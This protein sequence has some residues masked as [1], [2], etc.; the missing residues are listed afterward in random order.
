MEELILLKKELNAI[1]VNFNQ[2]VRQ[3]NSMKPYDLSS[4][5]LKTAQLTQSAL[6]S[7]IDDI[8]IRINQFAELWLQK[9]S[10]EKI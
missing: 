2:L 4:V 7:K 5:Q 10:P 1:G 3:L 9:S 8:K 6:L